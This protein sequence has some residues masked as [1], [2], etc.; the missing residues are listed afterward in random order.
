[1]NQ[2]PPSF[3]G[4]VAAC[5]ATGHLV[6]ARLLAG[7]ARAWR[8]IAG[9]LAGLCLLAALLP[10]A[11]A[12]AGVPPHTV[13]LHFHRPQHDYAGWGLHVW[14]EALALRRAVTWQQPMEPAGLDA[15]GIYF[16][17]P[18]QPGARSFLFILHRGDTKNVAQDQRLELPA[19]GREVW[20]MAD[21]ATLFSSPPEIQ[22]D[23]ALGLELQRLSAHQ[24]RLAWASAGGLVAVLAIGSLLAFRRLAAARGQLVRQV[25]GLVEAQ[26]DWQRQAERAPS[27]ADDELT[28]LPTR[29]SLQRALD[30]ALR[31]ARRHG[32]P[33]A[34]LFIDL[35]G[36]KQVN[37][38]C[39]HDA[40]DR[41]LT[42]LAQRF[43]ASLRESD[44]VA[45][46]GG[47]EFVVLIEDLHDSRHAARV[48]RKL[49]ECAA[50]PVPDGERQHRVS[51]SI[52][53]AVFPED[54]LDGA[55]LVKQAD[56]AMYQ[57]KKGGKNACCFH[58]PARQRQLQAQLALER[59][60]KDWAADA[61]RLDSLVHWQPQ[62][63]LDS[64]RLVGMELQLRRPG[65][66]VPEDLAAVL[67]V[68]E[69]M[70]LAEALE[71]AMVLQ[72]GRQA[73]AW[74][75]EGRPALPLTVRMAPGSA[76]RAGRIGR[77]RVALADSGLP[78]AQ[79][80]L[81]GPAELVASAA[82][83]ASEWQPLHRLGVRLG[84]DLPPAAR[85]GL[86]PLLEAAPDLLVLDAELLAE[87]G[88]PAVQAKGYVAALR[89]LGEARGFRLAVRGLDTPALRRRASAL[90]IEVGQGHACQEAAA[91]ATAA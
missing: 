71:R 21:T 42:T 17:V 50:E 12:P 60:L 14:G 66:A 48:A 74:R 51:A 67:A 8:W 61:S 26:R 29:A 11:A 7:S 64:G 6:L 2:R 88:A 37:D 46:V 31:R 87:D 72:A 15:Y 27:G 30:A 90:G 24:V 56:T 52:G 75:L 18:L 53:V 54:G 33:L 35:D 85:L 68:A 44:L 25:A 28:G 4:L 84:L 55:S 49:I 69:E 82:M 59:E 43:R 63:A 47:D 81:Q 23:F 13:R 10:A 86:L 38:G 16:D 39:G 89:L 36:F 79:L 78:A 65:Q 22:A 45:R 5:T 83:P 1:M 80:R 34:V 62:L 9:L 91:A 73:A 58:A 76:A 41:V 57:A 32:R 77:L 70:G 3:P 40:G 19:H 20:L